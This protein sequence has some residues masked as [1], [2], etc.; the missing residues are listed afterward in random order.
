[1]MPHMKDINVADDLSGDCLQIFCLIT[2]RGPA[3]G[4]IPG[5]EVAKAAVFD[6]ES[7]G[8]LVFFAG[9]EMDRTAIGIVSVDDDDLRRG[10]VTEFEP[11]P[12]SNFLPVGAA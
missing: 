3:P 6:Q 10:S 1:M 12:G 7:D 4:Q 5:G 11:C 9:I 2:A 8:S